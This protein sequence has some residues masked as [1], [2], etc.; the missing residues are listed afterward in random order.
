MKTIVLKIFAWVVLGFGIILSLVVIYGMV[1]LAVYL[2]KEANLT[3]LII[4][5]IGLVLLAVVIFLIFFGIFEFILSHIEMK[6]TISEM[7]EEVERLEHEVEGG[8]DKD[9]LQ[10][11]NQ[12]S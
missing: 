11:G 12:S 8:Q 10:S 1:F 9:N 5:D 6:E 4:F 3:R 2:N 7:C